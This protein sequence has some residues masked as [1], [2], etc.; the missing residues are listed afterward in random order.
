M[1]KFRSKPASLR[2]FKAKPRQQPSGLH[3]MMV[4]SVNDDA[5]GIARVNGKCVFIT[6]ALT[7][8]TVMAKYTASHRR[9]DEAICVEVV[10]PSADRVDPTCEYFGRCGG[11]NLQ[12]MDYSSQIDQ[13]QQQLVSLI[14]QLGSGID[15]SWSAPMQASPYQ[16]RHRARLA[17]KANRNSCQL[18]FRRAESRDIIAIDHCAVLYPALSAMLPELNRLMTSLQGRSCI[19]ELSINEDGDG[20]QALLI[21]CK[22]A[23]CEKDLQRLEQFSVNSSISIALQS[24]AAPWFCGDQQLRYPWPDSSLQLLYS[25][26]DFTQVN[27]AINQQMIGKAIEWLDLTRSDKVADFFCGVGNFTLPMANKVHC[28]T[29]YELVD[30]MV[31]KAEANAA[32]N[33]IDN[34]HFLQSDLMSPGASV[35]AVKSHNK[36]LLDP[37]RAGAEALC[38]ELSAS[39]VER[40]V[41]IS[42]HPASFIRDAEILLAGGFCLEK[43]VLADMF[44]QT[45]HSEVVALL[46]NPSNIDKRSNNDGRQ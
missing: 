1:A 25:G 38:T 22:H 35:E 9:F 23:L 21:H 7:G 8:E 13:K 3:K 30:D 14:R 41:Y 17:V 26:S 20:K 45:P 19:D 29:G 42:C 39:T 40:I 32:A 2:T 46:T 6:G 31:V 28:V 5:R 24:P 27:P 34:S 36:A 37:P 10:E 4:E 18:G 44:P 15:V 11:C 12:H 33:Q 43:V 16:Y